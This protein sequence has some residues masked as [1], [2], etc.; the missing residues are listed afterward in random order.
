MRKDLGLLMLFMTLLLTPVPA[1]DQSLLVPWSR[2]TF[3]PQEG[4][5][6]QFHSLTQSRMRMN[7]HFIA[8]P[9]PDED[10][11]SWLNDLQT[12][13]QELREGLW[14][15]LRWTILLQFDGGRAWIR[16]DRKWAFTADL[17]PGEQIIVEGETRSLE[18]N[19]TLCFAFDW[20]ERNGKIGGRWAGWSGVLKTVTTPAESKWHSFRVELTVPPF[21]ATH[22]WARPILGMDATHDATPGK[23]E[24][25]NLRVRIPDSAERSGRLKPLASAPN[26]FDD[27]IYRRKDLKWV[28]KAFVCGFIFM[29]DRSFWDSKNER[30]R[31]DEMLDEA[32]RD[33][34]GYDS[35]VL[36]HAYPRIGVDERSQFDF[37]EDMPGGLKGLRQA[38]QK[39]HQRGV[40]VFIPYMPWDTGTRRSGRSDEEELARI[41]KAIDADGIFLDTMDESTPQLRE[42]VDQQRK[43]VAFEPE[44]HPTFEELERCNASWAQWLQ[45]FP[46]IGILR[47]KWLEPRHMQHQIRRWDKSHEDELAAA[48][49]SGSGILVWENVFGSWNPW[50]LEDKSSL[51]RMAPVLRFFASLLTEGEWLPYFPT[52]LPEV[53][54]SGWQQRDTRLWTIINRTGAP[55]NQAILEVED[56]GER[57]FDLWNGELLKAEDA[58]K[59]KVRIM[60]PLNKFGVV[61]AISEKYPRKKELFQ[62][63]ERQRKEANK[64]TEHPD[65]PLAAYSVVEP[66]PPPAIPAVDTQPKDRMMVKGGTHLFYVRHTRRECGCYPDRGTPPEKWQ[67]FLR[68]YPHDET[69]EHRLTMY[70]PSF[71]IYSKPVTNGEFEAFLQATG[72][73]PKNAKNFLKHWGGKPI[74]PPELR[75]EPV[76]Y[77]SL[78]DAGAYARW[79]GKRLPTEWEWQLAAQELGDA[80]SRGTV[81]EWTESKRDDGHTRFVML[82]GGSRFQA[83]GSIWYF[84]GGKQPIETH[85][86]FLLLYPGLDRCS[87]IGFRCMVPLP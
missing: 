10:W 60:F 69:M 64:P 27:T 52:L 51:R 74:C 83:H 68:G 54:A 18:G 16:L 61:A 48:W 55:L 63:L 3:E 39:C 79:A 30:Y 4:C 25:R 24:L 22:T 11:H 71:H 46:G 33:F 73:Q 44:G 38:V 20:C 13:R 87:T 49:L 32:K 77:V 29:Y 40:K 9:D 37:F 21:E 65:H 6:W 15:A 58:G 14:D 45:S 1:K 34:G 42:R 76:V 23:M 84:P 56:R 35:L 57:Y 36:W 82:R 8:P 78:E 86:K 72:Y 62:L 66:L 53:Y 80:F 7:A 59:H 75:S 70:L 85:A 26:S 31:I 50:R 17:H 43:G 41:I 2:R 28:S 47:L 19:R 67:E 81:W 5:N 12:Y